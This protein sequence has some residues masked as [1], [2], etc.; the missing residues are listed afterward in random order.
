MASRNVV[1]GVPYGEAIVRAIQSCRAMVLVFSSSANASPH[2]CKEAAR[3]LTR[4]LAIIPFRNEE[5]RS[6]EA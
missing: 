3:A 4:D 5:A 1:P 2:I 6:D